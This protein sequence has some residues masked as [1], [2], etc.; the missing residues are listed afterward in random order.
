MKLLPFTIFSPIN[1]TQEIKVRNKMALDFF[2][3]DLLKRK[4]SVSNQCKT[5]RSYIWELFLLSKHM[6]PVIAFMSRTILYG[7]HVAYSD[8]TLPGIHYDRV[9]IDK[10]EC[11]FSTSSLKKQISVVRKRDGPYL[12]TSTPTNIKSGIFDRIFIKKFF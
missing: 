11:S 4:E 3:K 7:Q 9:Q 8:R 10:S 6:N 1:K 5:I 12:S 2:N